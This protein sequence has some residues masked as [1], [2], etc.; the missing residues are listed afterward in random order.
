[1]INY[2]HVGIAA[3]N[4]CPQSSSAGLLCNI[5]LTLS[6]DNISAAII[7]AS[8]LQ[9]REGMLALLDDECLRPGQVRVWHG[10]LWSVAVHMDIYTHAYRQTFTLIHVHTCIQ[11]H[12]H[13]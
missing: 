3:I 5:I 9:P 13:T 7:F 11:S 12:T 2:V 6:G 4:C 8:H 10:A 1:M